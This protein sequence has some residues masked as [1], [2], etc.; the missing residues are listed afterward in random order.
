MS[1]KSLSSLA[2]DCLQLLLTWINY[3]LLLKHVRKSNIYYSSKVNNSDCQERSETFSH[4][5]NEHGQIYI[6]NILFEFVNPFPVNSF[7]NKSW[8]FDN[9]IV[10]EE[11]RT[12]HVLLC[13]YALHLAKSKNSKFS[14]TKRVNILTLIF[15]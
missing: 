7:N 6:L 11:P 10:S 15:L 13:Y 5:E 2:F 14:S 9:F 12:I 3:K 1:K 4:K 8:K